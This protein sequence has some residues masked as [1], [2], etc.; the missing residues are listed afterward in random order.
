MKKLPI[1]IPIHAGT[2]GIIPCFSASSTDGIIRDQQDAA[3]ITPLLNPK[4]ILLNFSFISFL[5]S[6]TTQAPKVVPNKW[7]NYSNENSYKVIIHF[8]SP[9]SYL[10]LFIFKMLHFMLIIFFFF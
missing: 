2:H 10:M 3:I 4:N 1:K 5:K 6:N 7:H 9:H 8:I